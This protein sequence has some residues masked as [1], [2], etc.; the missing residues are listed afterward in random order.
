LNLVF[1][2]WFVKTRES[3][4]IFK[5]LKIF[6]IKINENVLENKKIYSEYE[7][8]FLNSVIK[9]KNYKIFLK[10]K[11]KIAQ[12]NLFLFISIATLYFR[13]ENTKKIKLFNLIQVLRIRN[14]KQKTIV[15]L[16]NLIPILKIKKI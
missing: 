13:D 12:I 6:F 16:F 11:N 5:K 9:S 14:Y 4:R 3:R 7:L 8:F 15:K 10:N 1:L 2:L